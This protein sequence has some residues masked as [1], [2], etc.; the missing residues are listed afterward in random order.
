MIN[1]GQES[2][3][4][5]A[6][7]APELSKSRKSPTENLGKK[8]ERKLKTLNEQKLKRKDFITDKN[9]YTGDRLSLSDHFT[10][11][12]NANG[13]HSGQFDTSDNG[14]TRRPDDG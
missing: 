8:I 6:E 2:S 9:E 5:S 14:G 11:R 1:G 10:E 13:K 4:Q 7:N 12:K 3:Q